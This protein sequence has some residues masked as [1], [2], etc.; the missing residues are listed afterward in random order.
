MNFEKLTSMKECIF[1]QFQAENDYAHQ[2]VETIKLFNCFLFQ[3]YNNYIYQLKSDKDVLE[4][5]ASSPSKSTVKPQIKQP[6][7]GHVK[8]KA[9]RHAEEAGSNQSSSFEDMRDSTESNQSSPSVDGK[10]NS[11]VKVKWELI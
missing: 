9:T 5:D 8:A 1:N 6:K 11:D 10:G 3:A 4:Q 7:S 2:I